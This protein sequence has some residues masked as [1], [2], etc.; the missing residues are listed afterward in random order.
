VIANDIFAASFGTVPA[1]DDEKLVAVAKAAVRNGFAIV[2]NEPG[3]KK[4]LCTL[5]A[6]ELKAA[7]NAA[8]DAAREAG[9]ENWAVV[10]H[11]CGVH[12]AITDVK[13]AE[14]IVRRLSKRHGHINLG[15]DPGRCTPRYVVV[16][17]DTAAEKAGFLADWSEAA[18]QD[19]TG[20]Q[21]TVVSPG[22]VRTGDDGEDRWVHKDGGHYWFSVPDGVDLAGLP[23]NGVLKDSQRGWVAIWRDLQVVVP[24]SVRAEGAYQLVGLVEPAPQWL[25]D[26][27]LLQAEGAAERKRI[28]DERTARRLQRRRETGE[29]DEIDE[30]ASMTPWSELLGPD[31]W[32]STG[33]PDSCSCMIW[34]RPG[35]W[36]SPKSATAHEPGCTKFTTDQGH[37]PLHVWTDNPP[38]FLQASGVKTFTKLQYV[39]WRD[40]A[41]D[42]GS[43]MRALDLSRMG[44]PA[45]EWLESLPTNEQALLAAPEAA[46]Q[47]TAVLDDPG[48]PDE[49]PG[50]AEE[51]P[52]VSPERRAWLESLR[53][54]G[55]SRGTMQDVDQ[56]WLR[57]YATE[58]FRRLRNAGQVDE[59]RDRMALSSDRLDEYEVDLD[60]D[61]WRFDGMWMQGQT[62]MLT[63][64]WKAGKT[65]MVLNVVK[66]LVDG[67]PFL[68]RFETTPVIGGRVAVV[69]AEMTRRQ[70][71]RW[72]A[73]DGP[74][75]E[76]R[77][78]V[79]VFHVREAGPQSGDIL[80]PT[81]RA[82][83][84]EWLIAN[85][86]RALVLDPLN[87]LLSASGI[88]ENSSSEVASWFNALADIREQVKT[89][90]GW[91]L[92]VLLVHHFGHNGQRGRG[93]SKFMD[94]PDALW[95]YTV[96]DEL[97]PEP[98]DG[99]EIFPGVT[100]A[101][102]PRYLSAVGRDVDLP[103]TLVTFD[104]TTKT[105]TLDASSVMPVSKKAQKEQERQ[106]QR[107]VTVRKIVK[108]VNDAA[109][110]A[111]AAGVAPGI[112]SNRLQQIIAGST[113]VF[114]AARDEAVATGQI[115]ELRGPNNSMILLPADPG[116]T[117]E[118][119]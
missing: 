107:A 33:L 37:G 58:Q 88:E 12:H 99:G 19:M 84:V 111:T 87:P 35:D 44:Q 101:S 109:T 76:A 89:A 68:G 48:E 74:D 32:T 17:V 56:L 14:R 30:W 15:V 50:P 106:R 28:Q 92:D 94:A 75:I 72:L 117:G 3:S 70:F 47:A 4:P 10:R 34:T 9:R 29:V 40:H 119:K 100:P 63:A 22:K 52:E 113:P 20:R 8:Q 57:D 18:G 45:A 90:L 27:I 65:T 85:E 114:R 83:L 41:G 67:T 38:A 55:L 105:L 112:T 77:E 66:S 24:P 1:G 7:D 71:M 54:S 25:V 116:A 51:A 64:K 39:A 2:V 79:C 80:D 11:D 36:S 60:E 42:S 104:K 5:N 6:A 86:V 62:V 102:A 61:P 16:D 97:E 46:S 23:G 93:S 53:S 13:D 78:R 82:L 49:A 73:L 31:G 110:N 103:K 95:T 91:D 43:A 98:A 26:R 81:R 21:P 59:L 115:R 96:E 118:T 69:N 108:E